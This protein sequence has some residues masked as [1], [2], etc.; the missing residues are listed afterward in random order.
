MSDSIRYL[1]NQ[2]DDFLLG[3]ENGGGQCRSQ[4][5]QDVARCIVVGGYDHVLVI[6]VVHGGVHH[7]AATT[8]HTI[9]IVAVVVIIIGSRGEYRNRGIDRHMC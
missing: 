1:A 7:R 8:I 4:L 6:D 3:R 5:L 9:V 2:V